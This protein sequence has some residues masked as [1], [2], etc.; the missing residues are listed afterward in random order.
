MSDPCRV[1]PAM[2]TKPRRQGWANSPIFAEMPMPSPSFEVRGMVVLETIPKVSPTHT[3]VFVLGRSQHPRT[4]RAN[5]VFVHRPVGYRDHLL[6]SEYTGPLFSSHSLF[7][8][9]VSHINR[10]GH[11]FL[12]RPYSAPWLDTAFAENSRLSRLKK[13]SDHNPAYEIPPFT[14]RVLHLNNYIQVFR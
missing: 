5:S 13:L 3:P 9:R 11:T 14:A 12:Y 8:P 7:E 1:L 6:I 4:F 10:V 2:P